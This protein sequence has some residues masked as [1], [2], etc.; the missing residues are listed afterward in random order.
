VVVPVIPYG[1]IYPRLPAGYTILYLAG[2][3]FFF[4]M[5]TYYERHGSNYVVVK[6]P[7]GATISVLPDNTTRVVVDGVTYYTCNGTYYLHDGSGYV[8]VPAPEST[9]TVVAP[10]SS[11]KV[12]ITS[13]ALN[14]R[15]GP[16]TSHEIVGKLYEGQV[17]KIVGTAVGWYYVQLP[18]SRYGWIMARYT[19][20]FAPEADG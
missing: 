2:A 16:S 4:H 8:V 6:A 3:T 18:N 14:V 19:A 7:I 17:V 13:S 20:P 1:T 11:G 9:P 15:S 5:G 10:S 12:I